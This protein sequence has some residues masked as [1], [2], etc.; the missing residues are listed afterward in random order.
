MV[1]H[2]H[3]QE[4]RGFSAVANC[5]GLGAARL[6]GDTEMYPVRGHVIRVR[7]PWIK[8]AQRI[9][10]R[11][12]AQPLASYLHFLAPWEKASVVLQV[13]LLCERGQLHHTQPGHCGSLLRLPVQ[14]SAVCTNMCLAASYAPPRA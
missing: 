8:C 5:T 12:P 1:R 2:D 11:P 9:A 4:L 3:A 14:S 13:Q 10:A 7:A 6:F